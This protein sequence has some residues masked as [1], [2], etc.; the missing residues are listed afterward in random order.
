MKVILLKDVNKLGKMGDAK[1]VA[2][3][4][5]RNFLIPRGLAKVAT[6]QAV[7]QI[8]ETRKAAER[9]AESEL[10]KFQELAEKLEGVEIVIK[11]KAE[12]GGKLYGSVG[13]EQIVSKLKE[14]GFDIKKEQIV[15]EK[16]IKDLGGHEV[17]IQLN[18]GLEARIYV[19]VAEEK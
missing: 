1:E 3:G 14:G 9:K 7:A 16:P 11:A 6:E 8:E 5:G 13:E 15:L 4:Y 12:E 2:E 17:V 10:N 19:T 18:H